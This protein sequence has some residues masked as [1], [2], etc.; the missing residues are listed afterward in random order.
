M[1]YSGDVALCDDRH[2][3]TGGTG[4]YVA[5]GAI[6]REG[7]LQGTLTSLMSVSAIFGPWSRP[8]SLPGSAAGRGGAGAGA[9]PL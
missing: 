5:P 8:M 7:E 9:R 1:M 4:D 3:R 6:E 2:L